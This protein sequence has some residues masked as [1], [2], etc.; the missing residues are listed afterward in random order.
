MGSKKTLPN[1]LAE[2]GFK[3][4]LEV[5]LRQKHLGIWNEITWGDYLKKVEQ[6]AISLAKR[7]AFKSGEKLAIIGENRPQWLYSQMAAQSLG[8]ISVGIYQESLPEQIVYYLNDCQARIVV[9]EDQEQVDKLLEIEEEIPLVEYII[10]YNKQGMRHYR[11]S[12]LI[13]L[14]DLLDRGINLIEDN[15]HFFQDKLAQILGDDYAMIAYSAAT[16]GKPKGV[17]LTHNSLIEA[18]KNL[19]LVEQLLMIVKLHCPW[20]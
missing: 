4:E 19:T 7:L 20:G 18:A 6:L 15:P 16:T 1:L 10:Y 14:E 9:V 3:H 8:G 2:R 13:D 11:H 5:A 17:L 12:K